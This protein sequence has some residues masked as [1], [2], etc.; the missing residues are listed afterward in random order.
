[1][2]IIFGDS[3]KQIPDCY[4]VLELDSFRNTGSDQ[5]F[6]AYCLVEKMAINEFANLEAYKKIH[7]DLIDAYRNQHWNYCEQAIEGLTGKWNGELDSFY[8]DLLN[9]VRQHK[10]NGVP[11]DWTATIVKDTV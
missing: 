4:T 3:T 2:N 5:T 7:A 10:E 6:T 11:S 9:R 1:M 8:I